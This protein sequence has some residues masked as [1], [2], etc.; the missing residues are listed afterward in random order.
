MPEK[1]DNAGTV[2][3]SVGSG[4]A[5]RPSS[6][7]GHSLLDGDLP[8]ADSLSELPGFGGDEDWDSLFDRLGRPGDPSGYE[9]PDLDLPEGFSLEDDLIEEFREVGHRLGLLPQQVEGLYKWFVPRNAAMFEALREHMD[10]FRGEQLVELRTRHGEK[11]PQ[12]LDQARQAAIAVGGES[13]LDALSSSGAGNYAAVVEALAK[14]APLVTETP[15]RGREGDGGMGLSPD[16]LRQMQRDPRYWDPLRR[17]SAWV[18][19][20]RRGWERLT[21]GEYRG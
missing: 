1:H 21:P 16:R 7:S 18:D 5:D 3:K 4:E 2:R 6:F 20:V 19:Q 9:L 10:A 12:L 13:L 15:M 14:I 8:D 11:T 17:D